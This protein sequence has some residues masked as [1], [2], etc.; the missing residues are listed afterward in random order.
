M[1][2]SDVK[3]EKWN[4]GMLREGTTEVEE[5]KNKGMNREKESKGREKME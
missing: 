1:E 4:E 5:G 2:R 3:E